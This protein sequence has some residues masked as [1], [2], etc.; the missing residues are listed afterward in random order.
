KFRYALNVSPRPI[1]LPLSNKC[2]GRRCNMGTVSGLSPN[3]TTA[4]TR[5]VSSRLFVINMTD[6][7]KRLL[8][9]TKER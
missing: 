9:C 2:P 3:A 5:H 8:M 7:T 1:V 6:K 4:Q